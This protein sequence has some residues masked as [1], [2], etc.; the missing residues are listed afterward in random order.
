MVF[1]IVRGFF[2]YLQM[3]YGFNITPKEITECFAKEK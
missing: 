1:K 3:I 2:T